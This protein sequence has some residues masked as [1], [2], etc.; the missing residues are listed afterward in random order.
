MGKPKGNFAIALPLTEDAHLCWHILCCPACAL[1]SLQ[2]SCHLKETITTKISQCSKIY[3]SSCP[4]LGLAFL[5]TAIYNEEI[6][7]CIP[8]ALLNTFCRYFSSIISSLAWL[9]IIH[10]NS[11]VPFCPFSL[12]IYTGNINTQKN[13]LTSL[14]CKSHV[15]GE[16]VRFT[17]VLYPSRIFL[18]LFSCMLDFVAWLISSYT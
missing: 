12:K 5:V 16:G 3:P 17:E 14:Q 1:L 18:R 2:E 8:I 13:A 11:K 10:S 7:S 6:C 4:Y 9:P 15:C